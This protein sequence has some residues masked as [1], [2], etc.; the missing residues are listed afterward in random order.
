[1][2]VHPVAPR[3]LK[4]RNSSVLGSDRMDNL[5]KAHI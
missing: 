5:L 2:D 4:P 1:V 3:S